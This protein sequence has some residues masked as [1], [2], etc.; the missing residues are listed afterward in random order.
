M[1]GWAFDQD[2]VLLS[3]AFNERLTAPPLI[4]PAERPTIIM[5]AGAVKAPAIRA[6]LRGRLANGLITDETTAARVLDLD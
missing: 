3:T 4:V 6:A 1:L 5:G 2:G